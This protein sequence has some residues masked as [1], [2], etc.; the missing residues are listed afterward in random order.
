MVYQEGSNYS[1]LNDLDGCL[2]TSLPFKPE[3]PLTMPH[4]IL[5]IRCQGTDYVQTSNS[6]DINFELYLFSIIAEGVPGDGI[7]H[8]VCGRCLSSS[9]LS[10]TCVWN[11][12]EA[13]NHIDRSIY[14]DIQYTDSEWFF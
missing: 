5:C 12:H 14:Q 6:K 1:T 3:S 4:T 11:L 13:R 10:I 8:S 9:S 7:I 2:K